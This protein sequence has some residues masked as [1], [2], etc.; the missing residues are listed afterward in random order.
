MPE[1][2][3]LP[4]QMKEATYTRTVFAAAPAAGTTKEDIA[5]NEYWTHVARKIQPGTII[6]V[7]PE[8]LAFF[9]TLIV[10]W[11]GQNAVKVKL[12]SFIELGDGEDDAERDETTFKVAWRNG[13]NWCVTR[14]ADG[15]IIKDSLPSKKD[16]LL[17]VAE[18]ED[19]MGK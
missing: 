5:N 12:L 4:N 13:K 16:A 11:V 6:E 1:M 7:L 3:L 18:F 17:W 9:A 2:K 8:D 14:I 10:L 19:Q 15:A